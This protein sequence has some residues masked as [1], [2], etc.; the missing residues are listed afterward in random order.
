MKIRLNEEKLREYIKEYIRDY[1][2]FNF[3][4]TTFLD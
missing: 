4:S 3:G 2:N 1:L